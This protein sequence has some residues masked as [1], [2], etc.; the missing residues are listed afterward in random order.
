M[1]LV[2]LAAGKG[3]R[4]GESSNHTPKPILLYKDKT[5]IHHKLEHLPADIN[6]II[7]TI[8]HLGEKIVEAVGHSYDNSQNSGKI[9]PIT[10]IEQKELLGTG[11]ALWQCKDAIG[12]SPFFVLMGDDLYSKEDLEEMV[13]KH[14]DNNESWVALVQDIPEKMSAG[15]CVIGEDGLLTDIIEDPEGKMEKNTMYTG[16][17]LLTPEIFNLPLVKISDTEYG[18][19]QTFIQEERHMDG[20]GGKR[21]IHAVQ[22]RYWKRI[23]TPEDLMD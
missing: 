13:A 21:D 16:G 15:K 8:G 18:L 5:L 6:E 17:C 2:I 4:M 3:K 12:N 1:K 9:V 20:I 23:T 22:A 14:K 7:I 10:Y 11:H 19:P